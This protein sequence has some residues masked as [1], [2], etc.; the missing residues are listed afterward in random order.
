[1]TELEVPEKLSVLVE[2]ELQQLKA[3]LQRKERLILSKEKQ[4][5]THLE[6]LKDHEQC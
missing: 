2:L 4:L 6:T 5:Q 3:T 1:M